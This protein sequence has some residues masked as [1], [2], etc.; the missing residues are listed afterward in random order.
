V[1]QK[2]KC[3]ICGKEGSVNLPEHIDVM[4]VVDDIEDDHKKISPDCTNPVENIRVLE[5]QAK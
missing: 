3:D 2:W 5:N 4:S 1:Q